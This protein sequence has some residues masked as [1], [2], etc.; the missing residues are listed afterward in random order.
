MINRFKEWAFEH[1]HIFLI[2]GFL[3]LVILCFILIELLIQND[4]SVR[5]LHYARVTN[6]SNEKVG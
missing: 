5:I 3:A 4:D 6:I 2:G 1:L